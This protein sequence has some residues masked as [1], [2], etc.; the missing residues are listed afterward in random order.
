MRFFNETFTK[1]LNMNKLAFFSFIIV[2]IFS[3]SFHEFFHAY[4]ANFLGDPTAKY[5]K[6]LS[7]NPLRHLSL[8]GTISMFAFGFGWANPVPVDTRNFKKPKEYMAIVAVFGPLSN[9]FLA[10]IGCFL[11]K[12]FQPFLFNFSDNSFTVFL[13]YFLGYLMTLNVSLFVFNFLP[14]PPLDGSRVFMYFL[15]DKIYYTIAKYE[16]FG[17]FLIIY[18]LYAGGLKKFITKIVYFI[19]NIFYHFIKDFSV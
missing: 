14:I 4:A 3:L 1:L 13:R 11:A 15:P 2:T 6:R 19:L 18:L 9:L 17:S 8:L 10:I 7:L 16:I 12:I 5:K